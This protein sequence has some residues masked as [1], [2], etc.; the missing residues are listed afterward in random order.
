M[1]GFGSGVGCEDDASCEAL[2]EVDMCT[3]QGVS[4][5]AMHSKCASSPGCADE[6]ER[7]R[8]LDG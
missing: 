2:D 3:I 8:Q 6:A 7:E 5:A 1:G 4:S